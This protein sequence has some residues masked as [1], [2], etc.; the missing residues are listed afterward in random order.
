[1]EMACEYNS[2]VRVW[3]GGTRLQSTPNQIRC[4]Y[5]EPVDDSEGQYRDASASRDLHCD[6]PQER[7]SIRYSQDTV[8][9]APAVTS[10]LEEAHHHSCGCD[11]EPYNAM[12]VSCK[13][14]KE[15][16]HHTLLDIDSPSS[17]ATP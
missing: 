17:F 14:C 4:Y 1:M 12:E 3:H 7:L 5:G 15:P 10:Q 16:M 11:A 2:S 8:V 9:F 13:R 6:L